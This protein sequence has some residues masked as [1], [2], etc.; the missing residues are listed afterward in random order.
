MTKVK[1]LQLVA[2]VSLL[3]C[4]AIGPAAAAT[5]HTYVSGKGSDSGSCTYPAVACRTFAYAIAQTSASGEIIVMDPAD[6]SPVTITKSI[7]IVADGAGPAGIV[8]AAGNA[9]TINA[10]ANDVVNLRGLTLEGEGSAAYGI[11]LNSAAALTISDC[12]VRHFQNTGILIAPEGVG[13]TSI[14]SIISILNSVANDNGTGIELTGFAGT[15]KLTVRNS[16]ANNNATGFYVYGGSITFAG[17]MVAGN[18]GYG[19]FNKGRGGLTQFFSYG[20]NEINGNGTDI[21]GAT[22]SLVAKQ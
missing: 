5:D 2:G 13:G 16:V 8:L 20:D 6:Y 15:T 17:S 1:F 4:P 14:I 3:L 21:S 12:F 19:I 22:L 11:V 10:G 18:S 7:S 9:I